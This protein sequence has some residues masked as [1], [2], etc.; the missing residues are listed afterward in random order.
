MN[1]EWGFICTDAH[2]VK[3]DLPWWPLEP[4]NMPGEGV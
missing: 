1:N 3:A 2:A 4:P